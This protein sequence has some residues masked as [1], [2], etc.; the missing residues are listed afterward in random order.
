MLTL[1]GERKPSAPG[2]VRGERQN[3]SGPRLCGPRIKA[4]TLSPN[5][6]EGRGEGGLRARRAV[7][8]SPVGANL[9]F[10]QTVL[11]SQSPSRKDIQ[12][13]LSSMLPVRA[14]ET[15]SAPYLI[16]SLL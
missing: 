2:K 10:A 9:G 4:A 3:L 7:P 13:G 5:G 11:H 14:F 1:V 12:I 15:V 6:G 16:T 8:S